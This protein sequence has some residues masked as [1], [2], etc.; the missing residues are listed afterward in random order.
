MTMGSMA[1]FDPLDPAFLDSIAE[2]KEV[3]YFSETS[4]D[5]DEDAVKIK[6]RKKKS[7]KTTTAKEAEGKGAE[8][9]QDGFTFDEDD[10]GFAQAFKV[11]EETETFVV[12][13]KE[14]WGTDL[15]KIKAR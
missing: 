3:Q 8:D 14:C 5:D 7:E 2:D 12:A 1:S 13:V 11:N 9:F 4:E 10:A 6:K 15:I